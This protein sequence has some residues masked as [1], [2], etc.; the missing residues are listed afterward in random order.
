MQTFF[1][2]FC[3]FLLNFSKFLHAAECSSQSV[4]FTQNYTN[5]IIMSNS[6]DL[7]PKTCKYMFTVPKYFVPTIQAV[8]LNLT[9][10]NKITVRQYSEFGGMK[11]YELTEGANFKLGPV[12]FTVE[13]SLPT[14]TPND[15]FSIIV[16]VKDAT[17]ARTGYSFTV[18]PDLGELIDSDQL[19]GN[20][21]LDQIFD[22]GHPQ[23]TY[24]IQVAMFTEDTVLLRLLPNIHIYDA[25]VFKGSL[26]D[27]LN[28]ENASE[29]CVGTKFTIINTDIGSVGIFSIL[30]MPKYDFKGQFFVKPV[31]LGNATLVYTATNGVT[32]F[33]EITNPYGGRKTPSIYQSFVFRGDATF[34]V[35]AGCVTGP[36]ETRRIATITPSNSDN[37]EQLELFGR[38]KTYVLSQGVFQWSKNDTYLSDY[39]HQIG[40]KGVIMSYTY[41][42]EDDEGS[43]GN[44]LIQSP[45]K[46]ENMIVTYE[47]A[48]ISADT[49]FDIKQSISAGKEQLNS[50][51]SSDKNFTSVVTYQQLSSYTVPKGSVGLL[52]RYT[53]TKLALSS[54][55]STLFIYL[56]ISV[57]FSF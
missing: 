30:V 47:V 40:R 42:Y 14:K 41:P 57:I 25:G 11:V 49:H 54:L 52:V 28:A 6:S 39:T 36:Q 35:F 2:V 27:V 9:G 19:V 5:F 3:I 12:N 21:T 26:L 7:D 34:Q 53:V 18:K 55:N 13:I 22:A 37:Y 17:P 45:D 33:H 1:S 32:I 44:Y 29:T 20:S 8:H 56:I 31:A 16:G 50:L 4:T 46:Q 48:Y 51:T 43:F 24:S 23:S 15:L 38:C 10:S